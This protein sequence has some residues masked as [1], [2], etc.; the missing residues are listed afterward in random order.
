MGPTVNTPSNPAMGGSVSTTKKEDNE[1]KQNQ[2]QTN[3]APKKYTEEELNAPYT[4]ERKITIKPVQ[5]FSAYRQ[6]NKHVLGNKK[7][8]I[9][10]SIKS[11]R[12]L[13]SNKGEIEAYFPE[14]VGLS[15][16]HPDFISR[17]KGYLNN[18]QFTVNN[19][20][21][22][23]DCSF[24]YDHLKDYLKIKEQED[25]LIAERN[26]TNRNDT[27]ALSKAVEL[28]ADK[29]NEL[30]GT[31]Y[32]FGR[33][34][35]INNYIL[36]RHCLL[37]KDV[38]KDISLINA[39]NSIRF[40]IEDNEREAERKKKMVEEKKLAMRNF[41]ALDASDSKREAVYIQVLIQNGENL[42]YALN[43]TKEEKYD[44]LMKFVNENPD[45]FNKMYNDKN[46]ELKSFIEQLVLRG[47]LVRAEHNQ[48]L[49]TAEGK[50]IGNNVTEA[51][52]Y[53][54]NPDNKGELESYKNKLNKA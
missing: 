44:V 21:S 3:S 30:E 52:A 33:P 19:I 38:A 20:G 54:N 11:S 50:F 47:E 5:Y 12:V 17:V 18:I 29:L 39:D 10:S 35:N 6:V 49:S 22:V 41:V 45:K 36:Y 28:W 25:K 43:R 4:D 9:G 31:K 2:E 42:G 7:Q 8:V 1:V 13:S 48:M 23:I 15:P 40:Y 27:S 14:L 32:Q 53:F 51:V 46:V 24:R 16:S 26:S 34:L 37:Y